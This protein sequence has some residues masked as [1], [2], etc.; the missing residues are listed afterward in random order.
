MAKTVKPAAPKVEEKVV[1]A[2]TATIQKST[3]FNAREAVS[4][5]AGLSSK[6][7]IEA[8]IEGEERKTVLT[9]ARVKLNAMS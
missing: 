2:T 8:F 3:D 6:S 1:E 9:R 5:L 4:K 7:D